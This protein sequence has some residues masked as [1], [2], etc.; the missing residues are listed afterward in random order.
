MKRN[1][2]MKRNLPLSRRT[3]LGGAGAL[4]AL[5]WLEALAPRVGGR[6]NAAP[7]PS[8]KRALFYYLPC[9]IHMQSWTP[10][11][12]GP[13]YEL[14]KI[15]SPLVDQNAMR[16]LKGDTMVITGLANY[17]AKPEGPGDHAGGTSA[18]LTCT[19]VLKSETDF[20]NDISIDQ[21]IAN[22]IG[23]ATPHRSLQFG[24]AGG[25]TM[26]NCDSGYSCA[27][28]S[29]ISWA[30]P[31]TPLPKL[32]APQVIFELLFSG[33]DPSAT[34]EQLARRR[35]NRLSVIDY[36]NDQVLALQQKLGKTDR[37]KLEQYLTGLR[38][39]EKRVTDE[40]TEAI[41][42][43]PAMFSGAFQD[44]Q[45]HVDLMTELM[46][47]AFQCDQTR[48]ITFMLEN[49]GSG[50]DYAF[51]GAPGGHHE[52]SHHQSLQTNYDKLEIIDQWEVAQFAKLLQKLKD[53]P[54]GDG[55]LLDNCAVYLSSEISDGNQ[56]NHDNMPVLLAGGLGGAITP[57][58]HL[59]VPDKT[60]LANLFASIATGMGVPTG[61]F[62][63]DGTGLL[64]GLKL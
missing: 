45:T 2:H 63:D 18:F 12:E 54:D 42:E 57:G 21:L 64:D 46:V 35:A 48:V 15:L 7:E 53:S 25:G 30:D 28:T 22:A 39:L 55:T 44:H 29:N 50:R 56:H 9:G 43:L 4:I 40:K 61:V 37:D 32:S 19:H 16:D 13:N 60:P 10:A 59:K 52:I 36:A 14:T 38:D 11:T 8:P 20:L 62:G 23:D 31:K 58:R 33:F 34:A 3:M 24:T 1:P 5:P 27:Y 6:A 51:I 41:C 47:L 49:A 17:P 26:G